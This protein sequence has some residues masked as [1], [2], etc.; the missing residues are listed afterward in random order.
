LI[1]RLKRSENIV[2]PNKNIRAPL[3]DQRE[4]NVRIEDHIPREPKVPNPN[5]VVLEE[6]V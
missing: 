6:S 5:V 3:P 4:I 1:T 2:P